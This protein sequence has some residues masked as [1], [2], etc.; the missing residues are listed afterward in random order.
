MDD[1]LRFHC[2]QDVV[3]INKD[4]SMKEAYQLMLSNDIRH[5]PVVDEN[6]VI[7]GILS[8]RDVQKAMPV[9]AMF[10]WLDKAFTPSFSRNSL[11]QDFMSWPV[12]TIDENESVITAAEFIMENKISA[13]VLVNQEKCTGI[14]TT[15]DLLRAFVEEHKSTFSSIKENFTAALYRSPIGT[16]AQNLSNAGI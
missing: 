6:E 13:L 1:R 2:S 8:D 4:S 15:E 7:V 3:F 16:I 9:K 10:P 14:V 12:C 11:V 5:L